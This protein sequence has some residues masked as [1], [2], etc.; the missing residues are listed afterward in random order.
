MGTGFFEGD[1]Q[2]P[3]ADVIGDDVSRFG[4]GIGGQQGERVKVA[5]RV[6]DQ[7]PADGCRRQATV[8]PKGGSGTELNTSS[9]IAIPVWDR[10]RLPAGFGIGQS[11]FQR[12]QPRALKRWST[13]VAAAAGR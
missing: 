4:S 5:L 6:T 8:I 11:G 2:L 12:V 13:G 10:G 3:T 7:H 9:R 1:L